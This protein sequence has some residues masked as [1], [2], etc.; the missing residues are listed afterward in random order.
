MAATGVPVAGMTVTDGGDTTGS[1][2]TAGPSAAMIAAALSRVRSL[3]PHEA[4]AALDH[5]TTTLDVRELAEGAATGRIP[6]AVP[7]PLGAFGLAADATG[8]WPLGS[9]APVRPVLVYCA[10]GDRSALVADRLRLLGY[11]DVSHLAGGFT[12]WRDCGFPVER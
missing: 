8:A 4:A 11:R 9:I 10:A 12:A 2:S 1:R 5:H 6:G 3:T 7:M